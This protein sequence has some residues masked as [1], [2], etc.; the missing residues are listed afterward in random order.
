MEANNKKIKIRWNDARFYH[1]GVTPSLLPQ[2]ETTGIVL[3]DTKE[4]FILIDSITINIKT[5]EK[6]P[7]KSPKYYYIPKGMVEATEYL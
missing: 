7:E 5:M 6:H 2:M 3:E 4:F 1:D